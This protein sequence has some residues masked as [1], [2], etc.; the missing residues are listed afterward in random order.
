M[1]KPISFILLVIAVC[2]TFA[3]WF[4]F[5]VPLFS[6]MGLCIGL[7]YEYKEKESKLL[8]RI[9]WIGNLIHLIVIGIIYY[10]MLSQ[11]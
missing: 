9:G 7:V 11:E 10:L 5:I 8:N 6:I 2:L 3:G 1:K 4:I